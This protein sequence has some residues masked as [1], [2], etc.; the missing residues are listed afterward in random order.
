[1]P[2]ITGLDVTCEKTGMIV[3]LSFSAPFNGVVFS[4]GHFSNPACRYLEP[5]GGA[6]SYSFTIPTQGCGTELTARGSELS[7]AENVVIV[8]LDPVVQEVWDT[9]RRISCS[10][11]DSYQKSISFQPFSVD[12]VNTVTVGD[13][14]RG[15]R[16]VHSWMDIRAG[17]HP[18][19]R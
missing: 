9:A 4:K 11:E 1:M 15:G 6:A 7:K 3:N 10:W 13:Q 14:E 18:H 19:T 16:R 12:S 2:Q 5:G 17:R 8:Q